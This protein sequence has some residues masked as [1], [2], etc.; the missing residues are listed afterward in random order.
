[1]GGRRTIRVKGAEGEG[2]CLAAAASMQAGSKELAEVVEVSGA[3]AEGCQG[4]F[5]RK[6]EQF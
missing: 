6:Q 3:C 5:G 2:G 4:F 1:M